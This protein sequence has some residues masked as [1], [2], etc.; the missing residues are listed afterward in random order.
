MSFLSKETLNPSATTPYP[1]NNASAIYQHMNI[2]GV[3]DGLNAVSKSRPL[4]GRNDDKT[5]SGFI[6]LRDGCELVLLL[7]RGELTI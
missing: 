2:G 5:Y 7:A 3:K 6:F 1:S 4:E